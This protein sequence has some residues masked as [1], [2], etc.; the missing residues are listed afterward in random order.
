MHDLPIAL[1]FS[2][3]ELE[4][5]QHDQD[6]IGIRWN[7]GPTWYE[8]HCGDGLCPYYA[9]E[10]PDANDDDAM[11][12]VKTWAERMIYHT[13]D[14]RVR[15]WSGLVPIL[16]IERHILEIATTDGKT[17]TY[18]VPVSTARMAYGRFGAT[19]GVIVLPLEDGRTARV[20]AAAITRVNSSVEQVDV[21]NA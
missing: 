10:Q 12:K 6:Q 2:A 7:L 21:E 15:G 19:E 20:M 3:V 16:A 11:A 4:V 17:V 5:A 14:Y 8:N 9:G 18:N 1:T 13:T